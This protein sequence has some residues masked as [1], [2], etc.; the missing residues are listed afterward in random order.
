MLSVKKI[1]LRTVCCANNEGMWLWFQV[2][3]RDDKETVRCS[4]EDCLSEPG[5]SRQE[6][7]VSIL[8]CVV[9]NCFSHFFFVWEYLTL[10]MLNKLRCYAHFKSSANQITSSR[11]LS[12][13]PILIDKQCRSR[14]I[15]FWRSQLIWIYT[16]CKSMVYLGSAGLRLNQLSKTAVSCDVTFCTYA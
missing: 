2:D 14:S 8:S 5:N 6:L 12:Q 3:Y 1:L 11:L 10:V 4:S 9:K 7:L 16:V 15:G 13:S